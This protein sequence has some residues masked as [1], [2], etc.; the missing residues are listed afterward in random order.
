VTT[1]KL[2]FRLARGW[3]RLTGQSATTGLIGFKLRGDIPPEFSPGKTF[4]E[5]KVNLYA[6]PAPGTLPDIHGNSALGIAGIQ[7]PEQ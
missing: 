6:V 3:S 1:S 5:L 2:S 4:Q 7:V